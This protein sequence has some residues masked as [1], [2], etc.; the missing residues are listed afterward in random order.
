MKKT[1]FLKLL[2]PGGD[3]GDPPGSKVKGQEVFTPWATCGKL[4]TS[5][6]NT[7]VIVTNISEKSEKLRKKNKKNT[8]NQETLQI[9][10]SL[11]HNNREHKTFCHFYLF[12]VDLLHPQHH[13]EHLPVIT[14]YIWH[15]VTLISR[16]SPKHSC[17]FVHPSIC[18]CVC[19]ST[20]TL[21]SHVSYPISLY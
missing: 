12:A 1:F 3:L 20:I 7:L 9:Q 19:P 11:Q 17:M 10:N 4:Q 2:T 15:K 21:F 16:L 14:M 6:C 5:K 18:E 8:K 13:L